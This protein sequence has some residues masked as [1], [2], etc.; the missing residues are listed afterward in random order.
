MI[1]VCDLMLGFHWMSTA[2]WS[3]IG[4]FGPEGETVDTDSFF[5]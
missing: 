5:C 4:P 2:L 3:N 1:A